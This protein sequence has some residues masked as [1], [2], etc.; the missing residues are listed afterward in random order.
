MQIQVNTWSETIYEIPD[1]QLDDEFA[2]E[3]KTYSGCDE[4]IVQHFIEHGKEV[5]C[6]NSGFTNDEPYRIV[7]E[8]K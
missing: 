6:V 5:D 1:E 7:K 8:D 4:D 3:I 2:K